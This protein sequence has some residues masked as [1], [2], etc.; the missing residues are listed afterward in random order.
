MQL[1][2]FQQQQQH[3]QQPLVTN[4]AE[5]MM[6]N[7]NMLNATMML[8]GNNHNNNFMQKYTT[9]SPLQQMTGFNN[10][11]PPPIL[12]RMHHHH[13]PLHHQPNHNH[14]HHLQRN[15]KRRSNHSLV[16]SM[17]PEAVARRNERERNRVKQVNDGFDALRK[18][19]PFLPDKKKLSKVE[20][21]RCAMMYISDL[22]GVV[23]EFD[24]NNT[25]FAPHSF[26]IKTRP[27]GSL[28]SLTS[29]D[30]LQDIDDDTLIN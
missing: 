25:H 26:G 27:D 19:V 17:D 12:S 4:T 15:R 29:D 21:L 8:P 13:I 28:S 7:N 6:M 2:T 11:S 10:I 3:Q 20:I 14:G 16:A 5:M 9:P 18:K 22:K 23:Q 30:D 1:F 24:N